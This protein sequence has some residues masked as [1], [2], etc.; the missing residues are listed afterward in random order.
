VDGLEPGD[1][2]A[3][4]DLTGLRGRTTKRGSTERHLHHLW[5][6]AR[7]RSLLEY[8]A[9]LKGVRVVAVDPRHTSQGCP[10]CG[11]TARE[12]R[13]SQALFRCTACGFQHNADW[14]AATNIA[15]RAGSMGVGRSKPA[16]I[17]RVSSVH[18]P[19]LESPRL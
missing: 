12:N 3:I 17:L 2:L 7:F 11:H 16:R 1:T 18:R 10:R 13:R 6:Y 19:P 8:K 15:Q 14:V 5:P 4:E 9:A